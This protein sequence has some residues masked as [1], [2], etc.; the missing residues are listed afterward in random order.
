MSIT[1]MLQ[2]GAKYG[3]DNN[4]IAMKFLMVADGFQSAF[5]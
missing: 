4:L 3:Q 1:E 5:L 2:S